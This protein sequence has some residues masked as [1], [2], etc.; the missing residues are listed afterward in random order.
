MRNLVLAAS[1][2][3]AVLPLGGAVAQAADLGSAAYYQPEG[4]LVE[5]GSGWYLRG[6][7]GY[8]NLALPRPGAAPAVNGQFAT[9][10]NG[11]AYGAGTSQL[12]VFG[13]TLGAGYQFNNWF[14][15]D[16]TYD[17]R[18]SIT[19]NTRT[20]RACGIDANRQ[21]IDSSGNVVSVAVYDPTGGDCYTVDSTTTQSWTGLLN[22]YVDLGTWAGITPYLGAGVGMTHISAAATENWFWSNGQTYGVGGNVYYSAAT[23]AYHHFGYAGDQGPQQIRNNFSFALMDG[24]AYDI[25]PHVKLDFGYRYLNMGS[26]STVNVYGALGHQTFSSQEARAGLRF[27]PDL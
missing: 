16:A 1:A 19:Q 3:L 2:A 25:A 26:V 20:R 23:G 24:L 7:L 17:W 14:R 15:M 4:P 21:F 8:V 10:P 18:Q 13:A 11:V 5:L 9:N 6:D 27:T 22:A 12:G